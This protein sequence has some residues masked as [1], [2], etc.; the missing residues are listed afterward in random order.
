MIK[1]EQEEFWQGEFG[2]KYI[3]RNNNNKMLAANISFF[4]KILQRTGRID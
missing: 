2:D 3:D 4:S 1:T